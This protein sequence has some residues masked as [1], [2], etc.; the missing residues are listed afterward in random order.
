M[1]KINLST[2]VANLES[3]QAEILNTLGGLQDLLGQIAQAVTGTT[4]APIAAPVVKGEVVKVTTAKPAAKARPVAIEGKRCLTSK[5]RLDFIADHDWA[6]PGTSTSALAT[7]VLVDGQPLTGN[8]A[9]GPKRSEIILGKTDTPTAPVVA[10][11]VEGKAP[12][13]PLTPAQQAHRDAP[14]RADGTCPPKR[15]WALRESLA[16]SGKF[17]RHEIDAKVAEAY[18][19]EA[20]VAMFG[21]A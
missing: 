13:K 19:N 16:E 17:D 5:N 20:L 9:I 11:K 6:Q 18:D 4:P 15:E 3:S 7:A 10:A 2:R 21:L 14:R 12:A 1:S 8:W